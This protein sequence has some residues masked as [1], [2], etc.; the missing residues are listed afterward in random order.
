MFPL[1]RESKSASSLREVSF[2]K[3]TLQ[4]YYKDRRAVSKVRCLHYISTYTFFEPRG[5]VAIGAPPC[6]SLWSRHT[7]VMIMYVFC[8]DKSQ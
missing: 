7:T 1:E 8:G 6:S 3:Y 5:Y 2:I 4:L